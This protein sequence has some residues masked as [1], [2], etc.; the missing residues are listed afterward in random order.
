MELA[1]DLPRLYRETPG[2]I[3]EL[4]GDGSQV[5]VDYLRVRATEFL[6]LLSKLSRL[7]EVRTDRV[8][9]IG[10]GGGFGLCLW[11]QVAQEVVGMDLGPEIKRAETF[12]GPHGRDIRLVASRGEDLVTDLG[13]FDLVVTQYVL[14]HVDDIGAVLRNCRRYVGDQGYV[15]HSLNNLTDRLD[16]HLSYRLTNSAIRRA[17]DS[18]KHRGLTRG[19]LKPFRFTPPHE[20]KFGSFS[21]EVRGYRLEAWANTLIRNGFMIVDF[22]QTRE[23]NWVIVT[24]PL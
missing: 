9:E 6:L 14:E 11:K 18:L 2:L 7:Q 24:R 4:S 15:V 10:C 1:G 12:L 8:L 21:D 13:G 22:F 16:W 20:P 5:T 23:V 3:E 19:L 17:L